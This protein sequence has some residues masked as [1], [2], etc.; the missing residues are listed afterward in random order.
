[1]IDQE[2][3]KDIE[4]TYNER[5]GIMCGDEE[6]NMLQK[7]EARKEIARKFKKYGVNNLRNFILEIEKQA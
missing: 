3:K 4:Y 7:L 6:P 2:T 1:M 5:L